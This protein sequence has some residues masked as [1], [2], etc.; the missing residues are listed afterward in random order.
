MFRKIGVVLLFA[1]A[2]LWAQAQ[3]CPNLGETITVTGQ[4]DDR[5]FLEFVPGSFP[6]QPFCVRFF[7][8]PALVGPAQPKFL[9]PPEV[10]AGIALHRYV[11]VTGQVN[12]RKDGM[13]TLTIQNTRD[14]DAEIRAR[15][16]D[17]VEGCRQ[18]IADYRASN[19]VGE[20]PREIVEP[21]GPR[22]QCGFS[23][24]VHEPG[25]AS[26]P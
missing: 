9:L 10:P 17:W 15:I 16:A 7:E 20:Y 5:A 25:R 2:S 3:K 4:F 8:G 12:V 26:I 19:A 13:Y 1:G 23:S 22:P 21:L 18:W 14:V 11:E 6:Y 24:L